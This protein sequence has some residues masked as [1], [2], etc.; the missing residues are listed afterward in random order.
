M[1]GLRNADFVDRRDVEDRLA[2]LHA[3]TDRVGIGE[4]ALDHLRVEPRGL[5]RPPRQHH[6]VVAAVAQPLHHTRADEP[7]SARH[8][9]SHGAGSY[10]Y[11]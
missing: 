6:D 1:L 10:P 5:L 8:E 9:S 7:R 11:T 2:A 3:A 4:I